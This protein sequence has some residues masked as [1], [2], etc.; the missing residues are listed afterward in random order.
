MQEL[1]VDLEFRYGRGWAVWIPVVCRD[2]LSW[3]VS[4]GQSPGR[5]GG[6][7]CHGCQVGTLLHT[8][9]LL[10][11]IFTILSKLLLSSCLHPSVCQ[12]NASFYHFHPCSC[13]FLLFAFLMM[14]LCFH[15]IKCV[16]SIEAFLV[17]ATNTS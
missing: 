11:L 4:P 6:A 9:V 15:L 10:H 16:P 17:F 14:C 2:D 13:S 7:R 5:A 12:L 1:R 8:G 3:S